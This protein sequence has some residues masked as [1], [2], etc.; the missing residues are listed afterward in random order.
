MDQVLQLEHRV[1]RSIVARPR[2][3]EGLML[4]FGCT[5]PSEKEDWIYIRSISQGKLK[6]LSK[7]LF[8]DFRETVVVDN[9]A[10]E[11]EI[12]RLDMGSRPRATDVTTLLSSFNNVVTH[13][14]AGSEFA[15]LVHCNNSQVFS[16][17]FGT[18]IQAIDVQG[19]T[20]D[21][22]K[23]CLPQQRITDLICKLQEPT[24]SLTDQFLLVDLIPAQCPI[25]HSANHGRGKLSLPK[26]WHV[27]SPRTALVNNPQDI[28]AVMTA[29]TNSMQC[30]VSPRQGNHFK[31]TRQPVDILKRL[32]RLD[33]ASQLLQMSSQHELNMQCGQVTTSPSVQF[34]QQMVSSGRVR[35]LNCPREGGISVV[36]NKFDPET[37]K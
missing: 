3:N 18:K 27:L 16:K 31:R 11:M 4:C 21:L 20:N 33:R 12:E 25:P 30:T 24:I 35:V 17:T 26:A 28:P 9:A 10:N 2:D 34:Q 6:G 13:M 29:L 8:S 1:L 19:C 37:S 7:S 14:S 32:G 22:L 36:W 23:R 5:V 15:C